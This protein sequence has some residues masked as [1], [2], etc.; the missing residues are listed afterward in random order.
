[1]NEVC[2]DAFARF[3]NERFVLVPAKASEMLHGYVQGDQCGYQNFLL[4]VFHAGPFLVAGLLDLVAPDVQ[5]ILRQV[6]VTLKDRCLGGARRLLL[7]NLLHPRLV[8]L[9]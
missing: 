2:L 8:N 3:S 6:F 7:H 9:R 4:V 5:C 1:V